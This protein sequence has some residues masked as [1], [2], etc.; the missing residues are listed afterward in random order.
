M[1]N[2]NLESSDWFDSARI[3]A[4]EMEFEDVLLNF[5][6]LFLKAEKVS[7]FLIFKFNLLHLMTVDGKKEFLKRLGL[8]LNWG[9]LLLV[10]VLYNLLALE[11]ILNTPEIDL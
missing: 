9:M 5:K 1:S 11:S 10:L 3:V 4:I 7:E 8:A 6:I 2:L